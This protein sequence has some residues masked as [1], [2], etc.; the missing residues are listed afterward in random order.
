MSQHDKL[1]TVSHQIKCSPLLELWY[2]FK[3]IETL[4]QSHIYNPSQ[5]LFQ[6]VWILQFETRNAAATRRK[7]KQYTIRHGFLEKTLCRTLFAQELI[8]IT[9]ENYFFFFHTLRPG[10]SFLPFN[11]FKSHLLTYFSPDALLLHLASG[12]STL[13]SNINSTWYK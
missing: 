9:S 6:A 8:S 4:K 13:P 2:L 1:W 11:S 10:F 5:S 7:Q 3:E 12:K